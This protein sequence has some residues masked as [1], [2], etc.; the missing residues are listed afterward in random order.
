MLKFSTPKIIRFSDKIILFYCKVRYISLRILLRIIIGK[1]RRDEWWIKQPN[2]S[3]MSPITGKRLLIENEQGLRFWIRANTE[4]ASIVSTK[5]ESNVLKVFKP[6]IGDVVLD[7]GANVGKYS[8]HIADLV[9]AEGKVIALEPFNETFDILC[10]NII[11]NKFE[12]IVKPVRIAVSDRKGKAK[13]YFLRNWW[14]LNS[15]VETPGENYVEVNTDTIDSILSE[16]KIKK[17]DWMK[18]DVEGAEYDVLSGCMDT[19]T[20]NNLNL[21]IEARYMNKDKIISLLKS[22]KYSVS[23]I[24]SHDLKDENLSYSNLFARK[25]Y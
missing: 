19:L 20:K 23:I 21:I 2:H 4:D 24:E 18:I 12:K 8:I 11:E 22:L 13:M 16:L 6:S 1:D 5:F 15:I 7:V 9:G 3:W 25:E 17:V 10:E 14:G